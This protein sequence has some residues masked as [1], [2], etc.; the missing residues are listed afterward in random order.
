MTQPTVVPEQSFLHRPNV[1]HLLPVVGAVV[2][3]AMLPV[4]FPAF[5][6][7][8]TLLA[9]TTNAVAGLAGN[10]LANFMQKWFDRRE[11]DP[12]IPD[13]N[14][15]FLRLVGDAIAGHIARFANDPQVNTSERDLLLT[16]ARKASAGYITLVQH[17]KTAPLQAKDMNALLAAVA[18]NESSAAVGEINNWRRLVAQLANHCH[19]TL[20]LN[21]MVVLARW[22]H[23]H[24]WQSLESELKKDFAGGGKAYAVLHLSF[25]GAV[26]S[27]LQTLTVRPQQQER[28]TQEIKDTVERLLAQVNVP[29]FQQEYQPYF[30]GHFEQIHSTLARIEAKLDARDD[31]VVDK[32]LARVS[33]KDQEIGRLREA[34]EAAQLRLAEAAA[35]GN[36]TADQTLKKL[37]KDGDPR[38]LGDFLDQQL[39]KN[40]ANRIELLRERMAVAYVSG[41]IERAAHCARQILAALPNDLDATNRLGHIYSLRGDLAAAEKQYR[42]LLDLAPNDEGWQASALGNLGLISQTR[43]QLDEAEQYHRDALAINQQLGRLE[44]QANQLGNLG[45]IAEQR[46]NGQEARRLWTEARE[47]FAR[48]GIAPRVHLMDE[49]LA[50]LGE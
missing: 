31:V 39:A 20:P 34:L 44:G 32:L 5:A 47:L 41:E 28:L 42:C 4:Y 27:Q 2:A 45:V 46:G 14:G 23:D 25:M 8:G 30:D 6:Q 38:P 9:G 26:L 16:F 40:Q 7:D 22:L 48:M 36:V 11:A 24:L 18:T 50:G 29:A 12:T 10:L 37:R 3:G 49:W 17:N 33:E 43:G 21:T 35:E 19:V 13:V 15:D 1:Q